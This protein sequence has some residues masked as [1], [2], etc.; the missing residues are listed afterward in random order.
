MSVINNVNAGNYQ[1][2]NLENLIIN[3]VYSG[4]YSFIDGG[5][6]NFNITKSAYLHTTKFHLPRLLD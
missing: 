2:N 3:E 4:C 6:I 1:V 5:I